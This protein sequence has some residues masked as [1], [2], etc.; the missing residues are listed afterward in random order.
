MTLSKNRPETDVKIKGWD[1][2]ENSDVDLT[3]NFS[4]LD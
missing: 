1:S 4:Y 2:G 3:G